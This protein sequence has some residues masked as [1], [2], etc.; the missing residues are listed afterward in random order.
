MSVQLNFGR[1]GMAALSALRA[2]P[3]TSIPPHQ[4]R[5]PEASC[6]IVAC[7]IRQFLVESCRCSHPPERSTCLSFLRMNGT[8]HHR[9]LFEYRAFA[10]SAASVPLFMIADAAQSAFLQ[11]S[12]LVS[13]DL[14]AYIERR[15]AGDVQPEGLRVSSTTRVGGG[16]ANHVSDT[17]PQRRV[18]GNASPALPLLRATP[19]RQ[20]A[21]QRT[22]RL[23]SVDLVCQKTTLG[24]HAVRVLR[25]ML[26]Q[27]Q[28][29]LRPHGIAGLCWSWKPLQVR[30]Q[31]GL[32]TLGEGSSTEC[33]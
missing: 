32:G 33:R 1:G 29:V 12:S 30:H 16:C 8:G 21:S 7:R 31:G 5:H 14:L 11:T 28:H 6:L 18:G 2:S 27:A 3:H 9:L 20:I 15:A 25:Q 13:D 26:Q 19:Q 17:W 23:R 10:Q 24:F 22:V 4:P